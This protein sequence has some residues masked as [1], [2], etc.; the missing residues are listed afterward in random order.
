LVERFDPSRPPGEQWTLLQCHDRAPTP[1]EKEKYQ[2]S[3][4]PGST[5]GPQ[6]VFQKAD[7]EPGSLTLEHEDE[8]RAVYKGAFRNEST[9]ADKMLG[10]LVLHLYANKRRPHIEK[11]SLTLETPYSPVLG[12]KMNELQVEAEFLAPGSDR[13]S[14]PAKQTSRFSGRILLLP[15]EENLQVVFS[16]FAKAL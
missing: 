6:A 5:V 12:V 14:L 10:H 4:P 9:G 13:P 3:R 2:Q 8:E 1:E 16:D 7:I 15:T 11:Y